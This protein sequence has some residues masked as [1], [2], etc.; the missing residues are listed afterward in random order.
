GNIKKNILLISSLMPVF[1]KITFANVFETLGRVVTNAAIKGFK[2]PHL[3]S[4][5]YFSTTIR[6]CKE[7]LSSIKQ[8]INNFKRR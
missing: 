6:V 7:V 2:V 1:S 4:G 8:K 5:I 3:I